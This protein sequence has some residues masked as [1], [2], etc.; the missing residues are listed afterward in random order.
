VQIDHVATPFQIDTEVAA[1]G[2][3]RQQL[4]QLTGVGRVREG[5]E[6]LDRLDRA[7]VSQPFPSWI[8]STLTEIYLCHACSCQEILRTETAGQV[9]WRGALEHERSKLRAYYIQASQEVGGITALLAAAPRPARAP[10]PAPFG[11]CGG[12][13]SVERCQLSRWRRACSRSCNG[14]RWRTSS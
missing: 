2:A 10:C 7:P 3:L 13:L 14:T 5:E 8:R 12:A 9:E 4:L 1:L 6:A 11:R